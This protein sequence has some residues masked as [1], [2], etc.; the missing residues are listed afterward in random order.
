MEK[1]EDREIESRFVQYTDF[2]YEPVDQV[3]RQRLAECGARVA[4]FLT[5]ILFFSVVSCKKDNSAFDFLEES[6]STSAGEVEI[7]GFTPEEDPVVI[8][9]GKSTTF[10]ISLGATAGD[11]VVYKWTLDGT[12]MAS[13]AS[14]FFVVNGSNIDIGNH[15]LI[16]D[17]SNGSYSDSK[18]FHVRKNSQPVISGT[19]PGITG[20][21]VNIGSSLG[22]SAIA[23]DADGDPLSFAW[24][25]NGVLAPSLFSVSSSATGS[26]ATLTPTMSQVGSATVSLEVSDGYATSTYSWNVDIV[27]PTVASI[28]SYSPTAAI[29][30]LTA[31]SSVDFSISA[32]A[33]TPSVYSWTLDSVAVGTSTNLLTLSGAALA[34]GNHTLVAKI[35]DSDSSD[36]H[37]FVVKRNAPPVLSNQTANPTSLAINYKSQMTL[38]VDGSD[39]NSDAI[40]Y[41]WTMD[42]NTSGT[43]SASN[44]AGGSQV[45]FQPTSSLTGNHTISVSATDGTEVTGYSWNINV[46]RFTDV[47]NQLTAGKICSLVGIPSVGSGLKPTDDQSQQKIQPRAVIDDGSGNWIYSDSHNHG[48]WIYNRSASPIVRLGKTIPAGTATMIIGNGAP[49]TT[50]EYDSYN[51]FKLYNP[52]GLAYD[53]VNDRLFVADISSHRVV[54]IDSSGAGTTLLGTLGT[55]QGGVTNNDDTSG[56]THVCGNPRDLVYIAPD[57]Y[58]TCSQSNSIKKVNATTGIARVVVGTVSG[59]STSAG[60]GEGTAG[61]GAGTAQ[62]NG[63]QG[64]Q[65]DANG[66]IYWTEVGSSNDCRLRVWNRTGG[67]I[68]FFNNTVSVPLGQTATLAGVTNN[69]SFAAGPRASLRFGQVYGLAIHE[70]AGSVLGFVLSSYNN[71]RIMYINN[72]NSPQSYGGI[73]INALEGDTILGTG[74]GSFNGDNNLG[75]LVRVYN[76]FNVAMTAN[77]NDLLI[78]DYNNNRIRRMSWSTGTVVTDVG[79]GRLRYGLV[80]GADEDASAAVLNLPYDMSIDQSANMLYFTDSGNYRIRQVNLL[81]GLV[82]TIIGEGNAGDGSVEN[83]APLNVRMRD[84]R[85]I[86]PFGDHLLY[87]DATSNNCVVR[88]YNRSAVSANLFGVDISPMKVSTLAGN[89][90]AGCGTFQGASGAATNARLRN[91]EGIVS[92]GSN[93]YIADSVDDCILKVTSS[94]VISTFLGTCNAGGFSDGPIAGVALNDP[95]AMVFDPAY[96][97]T[98]NMFFVDQTNSGTSRIRYVN[99]TGSPVDIAGVSVNS[100]SVNTVFLETGTPRLYGIA[101]FS[102]QLCYSAGHTN[103]LNGNHNVICRDRSSG[104]APVTLRAGSSLG[105]SMASGGPL[106]Y[107][108]EGV[109]AFQAVLNRPGGLGFDSSGNLYIVERN[110]SLIRKVKRWF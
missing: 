29:V 32:T 38:S 45:I 12:E 84:P 15:E 47:C 57:V 59:G 39:A 3:L 94:G 89:I 25:L 44:T 52:S 33:K 82:S 102:N 96:S 99:F 67:P 81:T 76:P 101:A 53:A 80:G 1:W 51:S 56:T 62:V 110:N 98:G 40:N 86:I 31:T 23:N 49:G 4:K 27:N 28:N 55:G 6:P 54:K 108:Q 106:N 48:I 22:F 26:S 79:L 34:V 104:L 74:S 85:S 30:I 46:N 10:A 14:P 36:S 8:T 75:S 105:N 2:F 97:G 69:C 73:T 17:A 65:K 7:V 68:S 87:S 77:G 43:L 42:G 37:T 35:E 19:S 100:N 90:I 64:I 41:T 71:H 83:E 93:L 92:D 18:T 107:E 60:N 11:H 78:S 61:S 72:L 16:A 50:N 88:G 63:P 103:G 21:A 9:G 5:L 20:N 24:K 13:G 91:P 109:Q 70:S 66:N 95:T 58:V